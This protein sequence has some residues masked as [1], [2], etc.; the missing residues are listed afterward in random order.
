ME[1][2]R[3]MH[4]TL[5][6]ALAGPAVAALI[7]VLAAAGALLLPA[8]GECC[9]EPLENATRTPIPQ[10]LP[11]YFV[12][13]FGDNRPKN[14]ESTGF[15]KTFLEIVNETRKLDPYAVIGTGDHVG[16]GRRSQYEELW[17][18]LSG[19]PNVWLTPGN[20]DL[21]QANSADLWRQY[22]GGLE[23]VHYLPGWNIV[24]VNTYVKRPA[25]LKA[26]LDRAGEALRYNNTILATHYPWKPWLGHNLQQRPGGKTMAR[27]LEDWVESHHVKIVLEGH[28][29]G[30]A[31]K[32]SNG[33]LYIVTGGG[34]A[35][36]YTAPPDTDADYARGGLPHYLVIILRPDGEYRVL[37]VYVGKGKVVVEK[38][39]PWEA[40][41]Y[42]DKYLVNRTPADL[43]V[44]VGLE[45]NGTRVMVQLVAPHAANITISLL[46][47][48]KLQVVGPARDLVAYY[49]GNGTI[50][51]PHGGSGG[52]AALQAQKER[53]G[54]STTPPPG[55]PGGGP[56]TSVVTHVNSGGWRGLMRALAGPE[57]ILVVL[58]AAAAI[59]LRVAK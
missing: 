2:L 14:T 24:L 12:V 10:G 7:V 41:I 40:R 25:D 9:S 21:L 13:A 46:P 6:R 28:W 47:G 38:L 3:R 33:T 34:G 48:G 52:A 4:A 30:Y 50:I 37:P 5:P 44:R 58:V 20:H 54:P 1:A 22:V 53:G 8:R 27:M 31:E 17:R 11:W 55:A 29:H 26:Q 59:I 19:L 35:P 16:A 15:P 56:A 51:A 36:G 45:R 23:Q 49:A 18:V 39:E 42:Q 57:T 43:P 32:R